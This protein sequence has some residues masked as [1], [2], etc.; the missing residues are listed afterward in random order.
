L[1]ADIY[2]FRPGLGYV[3]VDAIT[4]GN[5]TLFYPLLNTEDV[6]LFLVESRN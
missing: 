3:I 2:L 5:D 1:V 6:E 4:G